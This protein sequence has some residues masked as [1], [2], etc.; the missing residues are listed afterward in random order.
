MAESEA[1]PVASL[2]EEATCPVCLEYFSD[3]VGTEC[4]HNFCR[5]CISQCWDGADG[6]LPCPECRELC[7]RGSLKANRQLK[8]IVRIT[9]QLALQSARSLE[10]GLC[11]KHDE[12]LKVKCKSWLDPL[13][14]EMN[15]FLEQ[16][17]KEKI[18]FKALNNTLENMRQKIVTEFEEL[19]KFL[20]NQER[21]LLSRLEKMDSKLAT[22]EK[23]KMSELSGRISSLG[24]LVAEIEEK[25]KL[26]AGDFMKDAKLTLNKC[27]KVKFQKPEEKMKYCKVGVNLDPVTAHPRLIISEARRC[28]EYGENT[29]LLPEDPRRFDF[30]PCVL[31]S[32]GFT[33]GRYYWEVEVRGGGGWYVGAARESVK[34]KGGTNILPSDGIWAIWGWKNEY[35]VLTSPLTILSPKV[36]LSKLG[37][38][39]DYEGRQL[40]LYNAD[41]LEHLYTFRHVFTEKIYPFFWV[42]SKV[43]LCLV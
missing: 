20:N 19:R 35:K 18:K 26:A 36:T 40:S 12:K 15:E 23:A 17:S 33:T 29:K 28:V 4:G 31:G 25:C 43:K 32:E 24:N 11:A 22:A 39:L 14:K 6:R 21:L 37:V 13:K 16:Q 8:N 5:A 42:A 1:S 27:A 41:T 7:H 30:F 2:Q 9:Q 3:P 10:A 34:R 38:Y